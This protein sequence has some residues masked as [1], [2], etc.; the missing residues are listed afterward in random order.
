MINY[1]H[2]KL[3]IQIIL[4]FILVHGFATKATQRSLSLQIALMKHNVFGSVSNQRHIKLQ[5]QIILTLL[6]V[7]GSVIPPIHLRLL[8]QTILT[9]QIANGSATNHKQNKLLVLISGTKTRAYGNARIKPVTLQVLY[10]TGTLEVAIANAI[11]HNMRNYQQQI[12]GINK[13]ACGRVSRQEN[14]TRQRHILTMI[15][16]NGY[17]AFSLKMLSELIQNNEEKLHVDELKYSFCAL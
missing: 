7:A 1:S 12:D 4:T 16:V 9:Q 8:I 10:Q 14:L 17:E 2:P 13:F 15:F 6:I 11:L 5:I 3:P